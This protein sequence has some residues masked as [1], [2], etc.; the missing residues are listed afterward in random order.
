MEHSHVYVHTF[1]LQNS[2]GRVNVEYTIESR[3]ILLQQIVQGDQE[4]P[5]VTKYGN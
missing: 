1:C 2:F 3:Y 4:R 5:S